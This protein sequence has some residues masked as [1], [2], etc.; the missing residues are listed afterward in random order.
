[1]YLVFSLFDTTVSPLPIVLFQKNSHRNLRN[2]FTFSEAINLIKS[3]D[4]TCFLCILTKVL[5]TDFYPYTADR[6]G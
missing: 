3:K 4:L 1:M 2:S 5:D 6:R